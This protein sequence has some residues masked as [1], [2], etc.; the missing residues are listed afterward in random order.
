M[1][2]S[3]DGAP[4]DSRHTHMAKTPATDYYTFDVTCTIAS[5][6]IDPYAENEPEPHVVAFKAIGEHGAPGS[7]SFTIGART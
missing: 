4:V 2:A 7:Y 5:I 6:M 3:C 1:G